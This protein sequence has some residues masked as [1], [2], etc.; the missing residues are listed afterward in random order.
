LAGALLRKPRLLIL[1]EATGALDIESEAEILA[2]LRALSPR[3]A[4]LLIAHRRESLR[5]CDRILALG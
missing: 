1:D 3:P 5:F 2:R 4:I